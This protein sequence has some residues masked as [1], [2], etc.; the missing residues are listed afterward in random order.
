MSI[1]SIGSFYNFFVFLNFQVVNAAH[2]LC[3]RDSQVAR[4]NMDVLKSAWLA[5]V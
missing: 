1:N 2:L 3:A 5:K 4:D